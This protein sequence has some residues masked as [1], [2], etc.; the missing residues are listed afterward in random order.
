M[1]TLKNVFKEGMVI[2]NKW[3]ILDF[4]GK[5]AMGEVYQAHQ[6]NLGRNVAIK[7]IS[8]ELIE[9]FDDDTEEIETA[10]QRFWREVQTMAQVRHPNV[11]QIYDHGST[12]TTKTGENVQV[13]YIAME[14]VPG[15]TLRFTMSEEGF[16]PEEPLIKDW[17]AKYFFPVLD[18]VEAI[19]SHNIVHRD[20]KPENVLLDGSIPKITDFGLA[21]S[22]RMK[23]VSNSLD[24]RGTPAY[25]SPEHFSDFRMADQQADIYSLGKILFE[26][27]SGKIGRETLPYKSVRLRKPDTLF[28]QKLD[29]IIQNATAENKEER[30]KSVAELRGALLEAIETLEKETSAEVSALQ[31][32]LLS[33]NRPVWIWT[34]IVIAIVFVSAMALWHLLGEPGKSPVLPESA[35]LSRIDSSQTKGAGPGESEL[36]PPGIVASSI[37]G[38]DGLKMLYIPG[39]EHRVDPDYPEGQAKTVKV[40][41]FYIDERKITNHHFVEFLNTVKESLTVEKGIVKRKDKIWLY[42]GEAKEPYEQIIFRHG[43]FHLRQTEYAAHPVVRVTWYGASAYARHY[44]K[45]LASESEWVYAAA[46]NRIRSEFSSGNNKESAPPDSGEK[47]ETSGVHTH[48]MDMSLPSE[49]NAVHVIPMSEQKSQE[50]EIAYVSPESRFKLKDM[51]EYIKEWVMRVSDDQQDTYSSIVIGKPTGS[52]SELKK[53]RYPWEGLPDVGFRCA[54]S[55]VDSS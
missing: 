52:D 38:K 42:L 18:G 47:S 5:G 16:E 13:E 50:P 27:V 6:R 48:M 1:S 35:R 12:F 3:V 51:G 2:D 45:R 43:R 15:T 25:M 34:G 28:L 31:K 11:L 44:G 30:L 9:S 22:S 26:A 41:S 4:I 21:R 7:V 40:Q 17:L 19:H 23:P 32:C 36:A 37:I 46:G 55:I 24:V 10:L 53:F 20:L 49:G 33:L 54:L 29:R 14:Y 39:G 8:E